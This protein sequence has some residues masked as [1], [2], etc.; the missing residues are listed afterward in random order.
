MALKI[1]GYQNL[2]EFILALHCY[3]DLCVLCM[4]AHTRVHRQC[5]CAEDGLLHPH[6][7]HW[8]WAPTCMPFTSLPHSSS[9]SKNTHTPNMQHIS[10]IEKSGCTTPY[11]AVMTHCQELCCTAT[12][13]PLVLSKICMWGFFVL[14]FFLFSNTTGK[15]PHLI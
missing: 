4:S 12:V 3:K 1:D 15:H 6:P 13:L 2:L 5:S 9:H 8:G 14:F 10:P 11:S 7:A